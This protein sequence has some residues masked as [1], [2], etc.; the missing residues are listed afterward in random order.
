MSTS[1]APRFGDRW[2]A[3]KR[4]RRRKRRGTRNSDVP[5]RYQRMVNSKLDVQIVDDLLASVRSGSLELREAQLAHLTPVV[6]Q[7]LRQR[8]RECYATA[9]RASLENDRES[10]SVLRRGGCHAGAAARC[11][12]SRNCSLRIEPEER[13]LKSVVQSHRINSNPAVRI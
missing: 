4:G 1:V 11:C 12:A 7:H 2:T 9:N 5:G 8:V 6:D 10:R 13:P 3:R